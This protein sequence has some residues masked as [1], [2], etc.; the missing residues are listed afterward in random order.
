[1]ADTITKIKEIETRAEEIIKAAHDE[2][3]HNIKTANKTHEEELAKAKEAS[4][5]GKKELVAKARQ[6]AEQ[7]AEAIDKD[8]VKEIVKLKTA[9][10]SQIQKAKEEILKC[11]S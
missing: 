2:A 7:E 5:A 10:H 4:L 6:E 3:F 11:L 1:M 9:V 8:S